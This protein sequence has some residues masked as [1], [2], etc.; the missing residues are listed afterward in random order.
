MSITTASTGKLVQQLNKIKESSQQAQ[1]LHN[2]H[3]IVQSS[4]DLH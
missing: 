2:L 4:D 3:R 1:R